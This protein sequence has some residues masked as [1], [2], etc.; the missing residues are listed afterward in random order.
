MI[1]LSRAPMCRTE[2]WVPVVVNEIHADG[3]EYD[4]VYS[5]VVHAMHQIVP[6]CEAI[7][8]LAVGQRVPSDDAV[9]EV[10]V[11]CYEVVPP[12][13]M[14]PVIVVWVR[15]NFT[16]FRDVCGTAMLAEQVGS[17]AVRQAMLSIHVE[18][19]LAE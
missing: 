9:H 11:R 15:V 8:V 14:W 16:P 13:C 17:F 7:E 19:V 5:V 3:A 18:I 2:A 10:G 6:A 12:A 4:S 1:V